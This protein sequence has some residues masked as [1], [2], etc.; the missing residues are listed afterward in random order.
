MLKFSYMASLLL[1]HVLGLLCKTS[2]LISNH[3]PKTLLSNMIKKAPQIMRIG[4]FYNVAPQ[5]P[6]IQKMFFKDSKILEYIAF[7][8]NK[9]RLTSPEDL[10]SCWDQIILQMAKII[11]K[12][13]F[14]VQKLEKIRLV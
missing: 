10:D 4:Q 2:L 1:Q 3:A 8:P 9:R 6:C 7:R 11:S 12:K 5:F 13:H 14:L